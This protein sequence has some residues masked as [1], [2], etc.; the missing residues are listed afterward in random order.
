METT[1]RAGQKDRLLALAIVVLVF[2]VLAVIF[3]LTRETPTN[4]GCGEDEP[5]GNDLDAYRAGASVLH[6]LAALVL[7]GVIV[8]LSWRR[9]R[10]RGLDHPGY[11]TIAAVAVAVLLTLAALVDSDFGEVVLVVSLIT[12]GVFYGILVCPALLI[13]GAVTNVR[14]SYWVTM[15]GMWHAVVAGVPLHA[16]VVYLPGHGPIL[17]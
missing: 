14:A 16:L 10:R 9:N 11:P 15:A 6:A 3:W 1:E 4:Y 13:A 2:G 17:C 5:A 8:A 12:S 7:L